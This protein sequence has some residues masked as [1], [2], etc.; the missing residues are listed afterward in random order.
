MLKNTRS[1]PITPWLTAS[2]AVTRAAARISAVLPIPPRMVSYGWP[3]GRRATST[4][5]AGEDRKI[6]KEKPLQRRCNGFSVKETLLTGSTGRGRCN[7]VHDFSGAH[8][9]LGNQWSAYAHWEDCRSAGDRSC[10]ELL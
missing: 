6:Q 5:R 3:A 10:S 8:P 1:P 9:L 4:T 2:A 7:L